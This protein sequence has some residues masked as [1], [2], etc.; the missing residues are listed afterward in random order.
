M[1][2]SRVPTGRETGTGHQVITP[3][4]P[5][6]PCADDLPWRR[7]AVQ[8]PRL[9]PMLPRRPERLA[10][11]HVG[12]GAEQSGEQARNA[13]INVEALPVQPEPEAGN[14]DLR[15]LRIAGALQ[16]LCVARRKGESAPIGQIDTDAPGAAIVAHGAG[17]RLGAQS[18]PRRCAAAT[19]AARSSLMNYPP[20]RDQPR[21]LALYRLHHPAQ[22]TRPMPATQSSLIPSGPSKTI[23]ASPPC[24]STCTWAGCDHSG[25]H[26]P[27]AV[28]AVDRDHRNNPSSL[29]FQDQRTW[30]DS[31]G[32]VSAREARDLGLGRW[33]WLDV[34]KILLDAYLRAAFSSALTRATLSAPNELGD[35]DVRSHNLSIHFPISSRICSNVGLSP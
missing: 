30:I 15:E 14:F 12:L 11:G 4:L 23:F 26:E 17:A 29:G 27:E 3:S 24:P 13:E 6:R 32:E 35:N 16:P 28:G 7:C 10:G 34:R 8:P 20:H 18:L 19:V 9:R 2:A 21:L 5:P 25:N 22:I 1:P 33:S 31:A